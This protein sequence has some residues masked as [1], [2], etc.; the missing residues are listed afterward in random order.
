MNKKKLSAHRTEQHA[1]DKTATNALVHQFSFPFP[2]RNGNKNGTRK[3][4]F[5]RT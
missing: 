4:H 5:Q 2:M 3:I 1:V